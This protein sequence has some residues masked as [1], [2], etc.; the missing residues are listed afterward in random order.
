MYYLAKVLEVL[1]ILTVGCGFAMSFPE[2]MHPRTLGA[3][4]LFFGC[5][6]IIE[7]FMLSR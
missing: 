1:G 5:G 3:G 4:V 2:L 7:R 6:W